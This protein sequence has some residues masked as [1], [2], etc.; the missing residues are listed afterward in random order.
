[1]YGYDGGHLSIVST[2]IESNDGFG[3]WLTGGSEADLSSPTA[4]TGN[5]G[6]GVFCQP[7]PAVA[8]VHVGP[9]LSDVSG[10]TAGG[11]SCPTTF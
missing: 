6:W 9:G 3:L 10:N 1:M 4:L 5:G 8:M 7:A 11:V 2:T